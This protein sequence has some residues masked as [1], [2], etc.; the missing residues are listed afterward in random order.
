MIKYLGNIDHP[1][2]LALL[3]KQRKGHSV[4]LEISSK[5]YSNWDYSKP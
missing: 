2:A 4:I 5:C 3:D 1:M